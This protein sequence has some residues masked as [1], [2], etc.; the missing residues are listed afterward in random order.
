MSSVYEKLGPDTGNCNINSSGILVFCC[1]V[2][3]L[4]VF[5]GSGFK[6]YLLTILTVHSASMH[7]QA[8]LWFDSR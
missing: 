2:L 7:W 6:V 8:W 4:L 1:V 3:L 5:K